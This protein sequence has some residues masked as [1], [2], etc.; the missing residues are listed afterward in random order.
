MKNIVVHR[1][2]SAT[3]WVLSQPAVG[4]FRENHPKVTAFLANRFN[5]KLFVGLPLTLVIVA[6]V[7]NMM[8]LTN[9]TESVMESEWVVVVD[10][11]FTS[12]LYNM[13]QEWLSKLL[14]AVTTLGDQIAV[15]IIGGVVS[16]VLLARKKWVALF[17]FWLPL[18]GTGLSVRYGKTFISRERPAD[19]AYYAVE[20]FSFPSGHSTTAIVLFGMI[21]F[22]LYRHFHKPWLRKLSVALAVILTLLVCFSRIY[23]GVHYLS[24]VLAGLLLGGA[25]LLVGISVMEVLLYRRRRRWRRTNI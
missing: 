21:A 1:V 9:L 3:S 7:I 18:A 11:Q 22:L 14:Y 12:F 19:V 13:R 17:A 4:R 20:H 24:D 15:F 16:A 8:L 6:L 10:E 25:W 2:R 23:L 5:T